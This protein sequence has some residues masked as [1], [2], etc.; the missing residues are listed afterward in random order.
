[1]SPPAEEDEES[2]L[3]FGGMSAEGK[4]VWRGGCCGLSTP[5]GGGSRSVASGD[6]VVEI[7]VETVEEDEGVVTDVAVVDLLGVVVAFI[8]VVDVP[9]EEIRVHIKL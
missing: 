2:G 9:S 1:M 7:D 4:V 3:G 6:G 5:S 8:V